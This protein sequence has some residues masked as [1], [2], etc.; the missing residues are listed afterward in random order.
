MSA[1]APAEDAAAR[2]DAAVRTVDG[3]RRHGRVRS[4]W[5]GGV[6]L[7]AVLV[8]LCVSVSVGDYVLPIHE[9][10]STLL[11]GGDAGSHFVVIEL[12]L[13]R[14]L[15]AIL[16]GAGFG[17]AGA[18]FQTLLR[19]PLASPD[20]IGI[21]A[22]ASAA[23]VLGSLV[24]GLSGTALSGSALIGALVAGAAIYLL[25]WREGVVGS[26]L[27]LV[28]VG[29]GA[30][31]V[32]VISYVMTRSDV[33]EAQEAFLWLTG[34]LNGRS[35]TQVWPLLGALVVLVPAAL[36]LAH[37]LPVLQLG[38]DT[39]AGLGNRVGRDRL[40]LLACG[41]A[42]AGVATAAAG[43][44][45]FVAFVSAPVARALLPGRGAVLPHSALT[46][47]LLVLLADFAAQ[48]ALPG[49]QLPVGVVT[50]IVGAPYLLWLLART[51]RVGRGG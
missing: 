27:V 42:L 5:V 39:A 26:R 51:N 36:L 16:V 14:A 35:W 48:H 44:V 46:G 47:A 33:R 15:L 13:P 19:N 17:M 31:L 30:G 43:P 37:S 12:R 23:A 28:G 24:L 49:V 25:A 20:V 10:V 32:S 18:L 34:S 21:S 2:L 11:G 41:T 38:D 3:V 9:V 40:L 45:G 1:P 8:M 7:L 50:S 4:L 6:L 22:G 29:L